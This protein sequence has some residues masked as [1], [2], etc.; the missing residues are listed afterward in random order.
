MTDD[1]TL[2]VGGQSIAGWTAVRVTRGMERIPCDFDIGLTER[3]PNTTD[4]IV[5]E[6]DPCVLSI[7]GD[8][9]I[10]GYVDRV[11]EQVDAHNHA[12]SISGRGKCEDIVDCAA[13]FDSFQFQNVSTAAIAVALCR[14]FGINVKA[15]SPGIVHPQVCLNVGESPY[16]VIDRLCKIAQILCYEDADGDLVIGPLSN[17]EAAG[18]FALGTNA[19]RASYTRDMSQR[20]SEYRVYLV[21]TGLFTD[22][23]QQPLAEY[24]VADDTMPRYRPKAFIAETGDAGASVS[25][26]HALW[27][28]NRRIGRG[29]VVTVTASTW[30]D[31]AGTLYTPN[32]VAALAMPQLKLIDGQ[33]FTIGEVT[34]RRDMGGSGCDVTLMPPDAFKPEPILYMPLPQDAA[35]ALGMG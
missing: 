5:S 31:S 25:K 4:V 26:A 14:P 21:G 6:G 32:T 16:Q 8:K 23:G 19:E 27:E 22:A 34:Y 18:G 1:V 33:R 12:L 7:G 13:Q 28:C 15:L 30:R 35:A 3:Y 29:N 11:A 24:T 20:F 10:T 2:T 9:V 17:D